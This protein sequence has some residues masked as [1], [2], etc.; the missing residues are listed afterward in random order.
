M[1]LQATVARSST[2]A[3]YVALSS[4]TQEAIWL[5]RLM[6]DISFQEFPPTLINEDN[7]GAIELSKNAKHH[8]RTKHINI[9]H[10]F[11]RERVSSNEITVGYCPTQDMVAD[12]MTKAVPRVKFEKFRSLLGVLKID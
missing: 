9:A 3:E 10:H 6:S 8:E 4:A 11:V 12:V 1:A 5:R 7:Q 2:E